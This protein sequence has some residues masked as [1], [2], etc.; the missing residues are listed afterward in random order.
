MGKDVD[1]IVVGANGSFWIAPV[2]TAA[3]ATP[4]AA[5][6]AGWVDLGY[7]SE[8]GA[9]V[10]DSKTL[11]VVNVWQLFYGARLIV[12]E[13]DFNVSVALRQW[14]GDTF[15]TAMGGGEITE[16][17]A[18]VF[19]YVPPDP[20]DAGEKAAMLDWADGSKH[21]RLVMPRGYGSES[22][23]SN[24]VRASAADLPYTHTV[25]G[26]DSVTPW[27]MLTDDPAFDPTP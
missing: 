18:G 10:R 16:P 26:A 21:Y 23:E 4:V 12:T 20:E 2:G 6:G 22:V 25:L 13:R 27:Y 5:P 8:D 19:K 14:N 1:E 7:T 3:P 15:K 24:I 17:A 9:T 11:E